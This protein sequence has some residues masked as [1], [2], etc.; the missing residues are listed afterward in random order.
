MRNSSIIFIGYG[1]IGK[2][3]YSKLAKAFTPDIY[4]PA[5]GYTSVKNGTYDFAFI[6]VP[7]PLSEERRCD[8]SIVKESLITIDADIYIIKS[9]VT[10]GFTS[11]MSKKY[12]DKHIVFSPENYGAT[13]HAKNFDYNFTVLGGQKEDCLKVQQLLQ[14][15]YDARHIFRIVDSTTAELSKY[16]LNS[17]LALKVNF[18]AAFWEICQRYDVDY[19][20]LRECFIL[21]ERINPAHT[22][23]YND[24]PYWD[25]H[26]FNKDIP[27]IATETGNPLLSYLESYNTYLKQKYQKK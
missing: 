24:R 23:I 27:A 3:E 9:T 15:V 19:E 26:C 11:A 10:P 25:S 2:H 7:T 5:L 22:F 14:E 13:Q 20:T 12:P 1:V 4:D 17:Y 6:C 21:D 18:C 16:M 8:T